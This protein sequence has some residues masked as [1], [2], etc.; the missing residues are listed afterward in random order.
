MAGKLRTTISFLEK[1]TLTPEE[2]CQAD[3]ADLQQAGVSARAIID[4]IYVCTGFN[5]I[6]RIADALEFI[7][8]PAVVFDRSAKYLLLFGYRLLSGQWFGG[9]SFDSRSP[10]KASDL[11]RTGLLYD[12]PYES[13]IRLLL[14][15]VLTRPGWLSPELRQAA[16]RGAEIPGLLGTYVSQVRQRAWEITGAD[17]EA[18]Q[19][20][21]WNEE[22]IF[23]ATICAA[24]GA[25]V[26]R[27]ETGLAVLRQFSHR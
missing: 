1:L 24:I 16:L 9:A 23:E 11:E 13:G 10:G 2:I 19:Q 14:K 3:I 25:G 8:P 4:A 17:I 22:Q 5:V 26:A 12:D 7:V 15:T 6:V 27:L 21:D 18:L 20:A